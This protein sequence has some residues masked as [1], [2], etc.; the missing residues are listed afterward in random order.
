MKFLKLIES[1]Q[2][3]SKFNLI[4]IILNVK[5]G[6]KESKFELKYISRRELNS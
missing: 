5:K 6:V 1:S 2:N 3:L 4:Y